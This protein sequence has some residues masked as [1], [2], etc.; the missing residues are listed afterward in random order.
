[1]DVGE[2]PMDETDTASRFVVHKHDAA[3]RTLGVQSR[4]T[5][6]LVSV[7]TTGCAC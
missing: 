1:M 3:V 2:T 5:L 6:L 4:S 7:W